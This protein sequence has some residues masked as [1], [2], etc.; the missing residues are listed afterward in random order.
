MLATKNAIFSLAA[1]FFWAPVRFGV[2]YFFTAAPSLRSFLARRF[3]GS[4]RIA[5]C[6][7]LYMPSSSLGTTLSLMYFENW[8]V[9][10]SGLELASSRTCFRYSATCRPKMRSRWALA[11]SESFSLS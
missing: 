10:S 9:L 5:A 3:I 8:H 6:A 2:L 11:L 4:A 1:A 7:F